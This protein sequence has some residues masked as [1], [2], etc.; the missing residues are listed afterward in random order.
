MWAFND[1]NEFV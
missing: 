1:D